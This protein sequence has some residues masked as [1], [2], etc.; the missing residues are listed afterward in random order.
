MNWHAFVGFNWIEL[1]LSFTAFHSILF[2][3]LL[4]TYLVLFFL[5]FFAFTLEFLSRV[6]CSVIFR[7][8]RRF[9]SFC[10]HVFSHFFFV[11]FV[12]ICFPTSSFV[13]VY[14]LCCWFAFHATVTV[15][16]ICYFQ[17]ILFFI[18]SEKRFFFLLYFDWHFIQS[19]CDAALCFG[20]MRNWLSEILKRMNKKRK[21]II[22]MTWACQSLE[23]QRIKNSFRYSNGQTLVKWCE[24]KRKLNQ[25]IARKK[26][27]W[28]Q[29]T[30]Y[31]IWM[32]MRYYYFVFVACTVMRKKKLYC[33][34]FNLNELCKP[35]C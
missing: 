26:K 14:S 17:I 28:K 15:K 10:F 6:F 22:T 16:R 21:I 1:K 3:F 18:C 9:F 32:K 27:I 7:R 33:I 11:F 19:L 24:K 34:V 12:V 13:C 8:C 20:S 25:K 23:K 5:I 35:K 30:R 31:K 4:H 2:Y 29:T